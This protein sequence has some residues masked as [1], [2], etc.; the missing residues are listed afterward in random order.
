MLAHVGSEEEAGISLIH[1]VAFRAGEIHEVFAELQHLCAA[2][3][4]ACFVASIIIDHYLYFA[5]LI[6]GVVPAQAIAIQSLG[7]ILGYFALT[8]AIDKEFGSGIVG[9]TIYGRHLSYP[10]LSPRPVWQQV[11]GVCLLIPM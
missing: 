11:D 4:F 8:L 5:W 9:I 6:D 10:I 7:R 2:G 3:L 1:G